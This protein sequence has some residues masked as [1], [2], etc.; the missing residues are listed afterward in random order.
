[1][2]LG[3]IPP[4]IDIPSE[5]PTEE[6]KKELARYTPSERVNFLYER[7]ITDVTDSRDHYRQ[8]VITLEGK[9]AVDQTFQVK[10]E[11]LKG[12]YCEANVQ[13][14]TTTIMG[15][16]GALGMATF[17]KVSQNSW[18]WSSVTAAALAVALGIAVKPISWLVRLWHNRAK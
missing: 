14:M 16:L 13:H 8:R 15:G 1:M 11:E 6:T 5:V 2:S 9:L 17:D 7:T 3:T 18:Y 4:V 10:L 12:K